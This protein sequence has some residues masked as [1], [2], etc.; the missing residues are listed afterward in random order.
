MLIPSPRG[1]SGMGFA[2]P[3]FMHNMIDPSMI[4]DGL[5]HGAAAAPKDKR[6]ALSYG[7]DLIR[8]ALL[9]HKHEHG[10]MRVADKFVVPVGSMY[11]QECWGMKLSKI[12]QNIRY[13]DF[14]K[15]HHQELVDMGFEWKVLR[16]SVS[17]CSFHPPPLPLFCIDFQSSPSVVF[18]FNMLPL[19]FSRCL[20]LVPFFAVSSSPCLATGALLGPNEGRPAGVQSAPPGSRPPPP[21]PTPSGPTGS[22]AQPPPPPT[23]HSEA[24]VP[25]GPAPGPRPL[26]RRLPLTAAAFSRAP[27]PFRRKWLPSWL[28]SSSGRGRPPPLRAGRHPIRRPSPSPSCSGSNSRGSRL[29]GQGR[30]PLIGGRAGGGAPWGAGL[31]LARAERSSC[32]APRPSALL[33]AGASECV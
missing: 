28:S 17:R 32:R 25:A 23:P 7:W 5:G 22:L 24:P 29:R 16:A 26:P 19:A 14:Y 1:R 2:G 30:H 12:C 13:R 21:H 3:S 9:H 31:K 11:P 33:M 10:H 8:A 20:F 15:A 27:P 18:T 4:L 6:G